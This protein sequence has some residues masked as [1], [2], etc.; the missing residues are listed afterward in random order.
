MFLTVPVARAVATVRDN[1]YRSCRAAGATRMRIMF[2]HILPNC[3]AT[4]MVQTTMRVGSVIITASLV[5]LVWEFL[6]RHLNGVA[7]C[8]KED[9]YVIIA[10]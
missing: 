6:H 5:F 3:M 2:T 10:I 4:I 1:E 8:Q 9:S 7:C